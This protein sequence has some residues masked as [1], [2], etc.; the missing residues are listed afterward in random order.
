MAAVAARAGRRAGQVDRH[1]SSRARRMPTAA[2]RG[3]IR[4]AEAVQPWLRSGAVGVL[5]PDVRPHHVR[6]VF[7]SHIQGYQRQ[8]QCA[9]FHILRESHFQHGVDPLRHIVGN[10]EGT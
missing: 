5:R 4:S 2:A 3:T 7:H 8:N 9:P 6:N 10:R 1:R